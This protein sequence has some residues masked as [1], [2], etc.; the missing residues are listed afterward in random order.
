MATEVKKEVKSDFMTDVLATQTK[1]EK[2]LKKVRRTANTYTGIPGQWTDI[3]MEIVGDSKQGMM[4]QLSAVHS[5]AYN[6]PG[7]SSD[8]KLQKLAANIYDEFQALQE[9]QNLIVTETYIARSKEQLGAVL[10]EIK[11]K[12]DLIKQD[13]QDVRTAVA[14]VASAL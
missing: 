5:A 11:R 2:L 14:N 8:S 13:I 1:L 6:L 4:Q 9:L 7:I 3:M 12:C 10:D